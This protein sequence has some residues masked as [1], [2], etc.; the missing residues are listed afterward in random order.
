MHWISLW[1]RQRHSI[2]TDT[3]AWYYPNLTSNDVSYPKTALPSLILTETTIH[4]PH[5]IFV[6]RVC[7]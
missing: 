7:S 4:L 2:S 5:D 1:L 3:I 6:A